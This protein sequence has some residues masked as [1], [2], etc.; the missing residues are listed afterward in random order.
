MRRIIWIVY[1]IFL[2]IPSNAQDI[3][4]ELSKEE[5]IGFLQKVLQFYNKSTEYTVQT[6]MLAFEDYISKTPTDTSIGFFSRK[7]HCISSLAIGLKT[8][9]DETIKITVDT[10]QKI[11]LLS[12]PDMHFSTSAQQL[13]YSIDQAIK[14]EYIPSKNKDNLIFYYADGSEYSKVKISIEATGFISEY[15]L[16][17][18]I[19]DYTSEEPKTVKPRAEV[20]F[21]DFKSKATSDI[22][23]LDAYIQKINSKIDLSPAYT[24]YTLMDTRFKE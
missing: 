8:I 24:S 11:I 5:V 14:I 1:L 18:A 3:K 23:N 17:Y 12:S 21:Y 2:G 20:Y 10:V 16:F 22:C 6:K 13:Q 15:F 4:R 19:Q 9:Q 7:D